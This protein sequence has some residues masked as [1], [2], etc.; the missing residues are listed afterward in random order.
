MFIQKLMD[1]R[2]KRLEITADNILNE[3]AGIAFKK[4]E[5]SNKI[6]CLELLGKHLKLFTDKFELGQ[7]KDN[8]LKCFR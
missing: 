6:K 4:D 7:S 3:I 1:E 5:D 2:I 8:K